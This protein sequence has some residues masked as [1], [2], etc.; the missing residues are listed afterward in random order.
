MLRLKQF[1]LLLT[2]SVTL[3]ENDSAR[4]LFRRLLDFQHFRMG[5]MEEGLVNVEHQI[6]NVLSE[7]YIRLMQRVTVF[8]AKLESTVGLIQSFSLVLPACQSLAA[9]EPAAPTEATGEGGGGGSDFSASMPPTSTASKEPAQ[10]DGVG[11]SGPPA[12]TASQAL[13]PL[14][15]VD[16][17]GPLTISASTPTIHEM[18]MTPSA[19]EHTQATDQQIKQ[20][21]QALI[22]HINTYDNELA[23]AKEHMRVVDKQIRDLQ[24]AGVP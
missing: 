8:E 15:G 7:D 11:I 13:A 18:L 23:K 17:S 5:S 6:T 2:T 21:S 24:R 12:S 14:E 16:T 19:T 3:R 4:L 10:Q 1:T 20:I 22:V 9:A